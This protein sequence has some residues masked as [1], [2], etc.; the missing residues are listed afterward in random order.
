MMQ[1]LICSGIDACLEHLSVA[2]C[3]LS[4]VQNGFWLVVA[5]FCLAVGCIFADLD[6]IV[7][8]VCCLCGVNGFHHV[9]WQGFSLVLQISTACLL[10]VVYVVQNGFWL[11]VAG[12]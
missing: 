4:I 5:G 8:V 12:F 1:H 2:C 3:L 10:S 9:D 6:S 11:V 7:S